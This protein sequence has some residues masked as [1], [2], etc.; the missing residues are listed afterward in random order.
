MNESNQ[1]WC[2]DSFEFRCDNSEKLSVTFALDCFVR[3]P[4][5][6][7][8]STGC[9]DGETVQDVIIGAGS[10]PSVTGFRQNQ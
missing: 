2:S 4:L 9:F 10:I 7:I 6:W 5:H 3:E 1:R 8:A